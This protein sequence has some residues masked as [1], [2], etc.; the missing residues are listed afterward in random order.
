MLPFLVVGIR[1]PAHDGT[2]QSQR[3]EGEQEQEGES[4]AS[5]LPHPNRTRRVRHAVLFGFG[6]LFASFSR[7]VDPSCVFFPA[8]LVSHGSLA[9]FP[10]LPRPASRT[11]FP[12]DACALP[13]S[14]VA[15]RDSAPLHLPPSNLTRA[16]LTLNPGPTLP[17][18]PG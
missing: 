9:S 2:E 6:S 14:Q 1:E 4:S 10:A 18:R 11:D 8:P 15:I 12:C 17:E 3:Q 5:H 16:E 7:P 13:S